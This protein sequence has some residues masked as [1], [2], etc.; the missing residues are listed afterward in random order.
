MA[1]E[2]SGPAVPGAAIALPAAMRLFAFL[3][4]VALGC[5]GSEFAINNGDN[6]TGDTATAEDSAAVV[7]D[8]GNTSQTDGSPGADAAGPDTA[9]RPDTPPPCATTAVP[10]VACA[11]VEYHGH[12]DIAP[13]VYLAPALSPNVSHSIAFDLQEQGRI[14][15]IGLKARRN[16]LGSGV[17]GTVTVTAYYVPCPGT[18]IPMGKHTKPAAEVMDGTVFYFNP[19]TTGSVVPYLPFMKK[20]DRIAFSFETTSTRYTWDLRGAATPGS[21]PYRF[22]WSTKAGS[23]AWSPQAGQFAATMTYIN[24]CM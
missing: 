15:K 1:T 6:T 5:S 13:T 23:A 7:P 4:V 8:S 18:L 14:E 3:S 22:V 17:D 12:H 9:M 24:R 11:P 20:G 16:D 19:G 10:A 2:E 21:D